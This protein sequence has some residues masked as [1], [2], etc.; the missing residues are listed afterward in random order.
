[1]HFVCTACFG[2][3]CR[4]LGVRIEL[5]RNSFTQWTQNPGLDESRLL[6]SFKC[7]QTGEHEGGVKHRH[8]MTPHKDEMWRTAVMEEPDK[9]GGYGSVKERDLNLNCVRVCVWENLFLFVA[10]PE[11]TFPLCRSSTFSPR[12]EG[13]GAVGPCEK[14]QEPNPA[15]KILSSHFLIVIIK[16]LYGI[17]LFLTV[18]S[19]L[20]LHYKSM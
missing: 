4:H 16:P 17:H 15:N 9:G 5:M 6:G 7:V 13:G 19:I 1:M 2:L 12:K 8:H 11:V 18:E 14:H 3:L 10:L 20:N